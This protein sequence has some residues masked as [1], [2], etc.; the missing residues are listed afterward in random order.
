[1][2]LPLSARPRSGEELASFGEAVE[3][4]VEVEQTGAG[5]PGAET[6]GHLVVAGVVV[7][8]QEAPEFVAGPYV[9]TWVHVEPAE[10]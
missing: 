8:V 10:S 3:E 2:S 9:V 6:F 4:Q 5:L 1:M 7:E